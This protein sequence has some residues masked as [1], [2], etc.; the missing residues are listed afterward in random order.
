MV[1][2]C[3]MLYVNASW[4]LLTTGYDPVTSQDSFG[5]HT[6]ASQKY[7]QG[8]ITFY[9][10]QGGAMDNFIRGPLSLVGTDARAS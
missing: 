6:D 3:L 4:S 5:S 9:M 10:D 8:T 7:F 2:L 1:D